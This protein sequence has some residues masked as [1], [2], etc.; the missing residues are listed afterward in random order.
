MN[1][2]AGL[3]ALGVLMVPVASRAQGLEDTRKAFSHPAFSA[4][5]ARGE[6]RWPA[7]LLQ[8]DRVGFLADQAGKAA[9]VFEELGKPDGPVPLA[10]RL[11]ATSIPH[12][13]K[14]AA[15]AGAGHVALWVAPNVSV[16]ELTV[17]KELAV[18]SGLV[19]VLWDAR[20]APGAPVFTLGLSPCGRLEH[21][22]CAESPDDCGPP[23]CVALTYAPTPQGTFVSSTRRAVDGQGACG[24]IMPNEHVIAPSP[25][26]GAWLTSLSGSCPPLPALSELTADHLKGFSTMVAPSTVCGHA[27]VMVQEATTLAQLMPL[28][29]ALQAGGVTSVELPAWTAPV[30]QGAGHPRVLAL[31]P[32]P[33]ELVVERASGALKANAAAET[34]R[35]LRKTLGQCV[36]QLRVTGQQPPATFHFTTK[37][38]PAGTVLSTRLAADAAPLSSTCVEDVVKA[39]RFTKAARGSEVVVLVTVGAAR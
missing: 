20:V 35:T 12:R 4:A 5:T 27:R 14:G 1:R 30:C 25:A 3:V 10:T 29:T 18:A 33:L 36:D 23:T 19:P 32:A 24:D 17:V 8:R 9:V 22:D 2:C 6:A 21:R 28:L 39:A 15:A 13:L 31:R 11:A 37:V 38:T 7:V 16:G 26:D 34:V